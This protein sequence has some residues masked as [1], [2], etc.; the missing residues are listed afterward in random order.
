[1]I[2][3]IVESCVLLL[4]INKRISGVGKD[5]ARMDRN[6]KL[7]SAVGIRQHQRRP[8]SASASNTKGLFFFLQ[9]I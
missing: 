1:M 9:S 6:K 7:K 2:I 3:I 8:V 5:S 4:N